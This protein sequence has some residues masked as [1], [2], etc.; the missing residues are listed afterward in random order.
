MKKETMLSEK[1]ALPEQIFK[2][3]STKTVVELFAK[4]ATIIPAHR[5]SAA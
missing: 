2:E 4:M 5:P 3:I 1:G